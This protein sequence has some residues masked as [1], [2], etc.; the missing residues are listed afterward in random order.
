MTTD[1][2][3]LSFVMAGG[4]GTRLKI[5]TR[6]ICKPAVDIL[7]HYRIFDFVATNITDT[8]IPVSLRSG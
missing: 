7:G 6:D 8:G 1:S 2:H 3:V 5:L 4:Q